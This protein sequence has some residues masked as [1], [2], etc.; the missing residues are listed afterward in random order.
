MAETCCAAG[1]Q[2]G[3]GDYFVPWHV[4]FHRVEAA[5][6]AARGCSEEA[7]Q[8]QCSAVSGSDLQPAS[9]QCAASAAPADVEAPGCLHQAERVEGEQ[10]V[11]GSSATGS[12][13]DAAHADEGVPVRRIRTCQRQA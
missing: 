7:A 5:A 13:R 6:A 8:R 2:S 4:P 3:G 1:T 9:H 10:D 11:Q 12:S